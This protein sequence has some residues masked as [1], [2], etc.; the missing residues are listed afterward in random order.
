M[1]NI[2][3]YSTAHCHLCDDAKAII[4]NALNTNCMLN[5]YN[6]NT[7]DICDDEDLYAQYALEIPVVTIH[8]ISTNP[9]ILKWPFDE[10]TIKKSL[11]KFY[12]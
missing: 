4:H 3:L 2:T 11:S 12:V 6:F 7:I 10:E 9:L 8:T 1:I 5:N